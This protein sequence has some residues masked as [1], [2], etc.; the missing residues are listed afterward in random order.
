M[1]SLETN[2]LP[3]TSEADDIG[4]V[5]V[6]VRNGMI[7]TFAVLL[8]LGLGLA[9]LFRFAPVVGSAANLASYKDM[10]LI[11]ASVLVFSAAFVTV[12]LLIVVLFLV[13]YIYQ[14][15]QTQVVPRVNE[16]NTKVNQIT[17]K[18]DG[19][20]GNAQGIVGN[21]RDSSDAVTS[22]TVFTAEKVV[23]PVIRVAGLFAGVKA[24]ASALAHRDDPRDEVPQPTT[25]GAERP[26][27]Q[28]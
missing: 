8:I 4:K 13:N 10:W 9:L 12:V 26:T 25:N 23:S 11:F 22:T 16:L 14:Q 24:A 5:L 15:V 21:V 6:W 2:N 3:P 1:D 7:I 19:V 17:D 27:E 18:L 28:R 20:V